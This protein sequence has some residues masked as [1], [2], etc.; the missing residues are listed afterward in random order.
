MNMKRFSKIGILLLLIAVSVFAMVSC[1]KDPAATGDQIS[2]K[3]DPQLV[4]LLGEELDFSNGVLEVKTGETVSE[5]A[6]NA[7]GVTVTGYDK[8]KL[9]E[10]TLTIT[11]NDLT[12]TIK[13]TVT[14]RMQAVEFVADYLVG[15]K[16][17]TSK[18]RLKI[19]RNDGTTFTV[20]FNNEK[21]TVS[22]FD[23]TTSGS[24][25]LTAKY[26][27]G[28]ES[29]ET[30]FNVTVHDVE[31]VDFHAPKKVAYDSHEEALDLTDGYLTLKGNGGALSKKVELTDEMV[32]G[33]DL[34]AV[35]KTNSPLDQK[36]TVSYGGKS[37][38]YS[39]KLTYTDISYF[40]DQV[41]AF[42][43]MDWMGEEMP[44]YTDAQGELALE[45]IEIYM[46]LSKADKA[47]IKGDD[48]LNVAR[49]AL[50]YGMDSME[51]E[52]EALSGGFMLDAGELSFTCESPAAVQTAIEMLEDADNDIYVL[53]PMLMAIIEEFA[54]EEL[55]T[56]VYFGDFGMIELETYEAIAEILEHALE[57]HEL[58]SEIPADWKTQG[59]NNF[60]TEIEDVYDA[61]VMSG[62][63][64]TF[65]SEVYYRVSEWRDNDDAFEILYT[66]YYGLEDAEALTELSKVRLPGELELLASYIAMALDQV[67]AISSYMQ[68]DTSVFMYY[69]YMS[70]E[71]AAEIKASDDQML[72]DLYALLP[73]NGALGLDDSVSFDFDQMLEY[74]RTME[75]GFYNFS[76]GLLGIDA[77]HT[78]M[79]RYMELVMNVMEND[80]FEG[81]AE[82]NAA[83]E[84]LFALYVQLSPTQQFNF[85]S[86]LNAFYGMGIPP[87]AFDDS[88]E[89]AEMTCLFVDILNDYYRGKFSDGA[90]SAYNNLVL[91]MEIYAQRASYE[92]WL[93]EFRTK[94]AAV[95]S[96]Y[97]GMNV[98]DRAAFE[99]Y[100]I[101]AYNQYTAILARLTPPI[102]ATDLGDWADD[103]EEL[104]AAVTDLDVAYYLIE[105]DMLVYSLFFSAF[106]RAQTIV[107]RILTEAPA[108]IVNAYL[109]EDLYSYEVETEGDGMG[110]GESG[111][112][113]VE[114]VSMTYEYAFNL[115]RSMYVYYQLTLLGGESAYD[116]YQAG[117]LGLFLE[118][119][120]AITWTYLYSDDDPTT[121]NF[122]KAKVLQALATFRT[123]SADEQIL[124]I[125]MEGEQ[126]FYYTALVEF[127]EEN[128]TEKAAEMALKVLELEQLHMMYLAIGDAA[129]LQALQEAVAAAETMY[130]ALGDGADKASFADFEE[131]YA[132]YMESCEEL[133]AEA[134]NPAA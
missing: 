43:E 81:S 132:F 128:Y 44:E 77:Y 7:E 35:N 93:T 67:N 96:A 118:Q 20:I 55:M 52:F 54:D 19:T 60:A 13:V 28:E 117:N 32:S 125:L 22:G 21:V 113:T 76:G 17:D 26:V 108:E 72:K 97:E 89:F 130:E 49:T 83:V 100:L 2:V 38:E 24:K 10:Q 127:F 70:L 122:D 107:D 86:T 9:G 110:T 14:E 53:T 123:L 36:L 73:V 59:V 82:Y 109:H 29:Y 64:G 68:M 126:G 45:L 30:H 25:S 114:T 37:Y 133:I 80:A 131:A 8:N 87:L 5:I 51:E 98:A 16:F 63:A 119:S 41:G 71:T 47:Y 95:K 106:E 91:A 3:E 112:G 34:T 103:F 33:F 134:T 85:L 105:N 104:K 12:T 92:N 94:M 58:F 78:L 15:D 42:A 75:G 102:V 84:E 129:S 27:N 61:I 56:E 65:A 111:S 116:L 120:S 121:P 57:V 79:D 101:D 69:Y 66:Y 39:V 31:S 62:Y 18:G 124:F 6:L 99:T 40:L 23:S 46:D 48:Y 90:K 4:Y 74:L 1:N 115:Y 11:Y 50:M 88:G